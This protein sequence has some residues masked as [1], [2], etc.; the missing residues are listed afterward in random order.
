MRPLLLLLASTSIAAAEPT[1]EKVA[2]F[3][4]QVTGVTVSKTGRVFVNFPRWTEDAPVSVAEVKDGKVVPYPDAGWNGWRNAAKLS[5]KDHWICVQS[6]VADGD[7]LWVLDPASPA[8][9]G[10]VKDGAKLVAIDLATN[11]VVKTIS[12]GDDVAPPSSYLNDVRFSPD[13]KTAFLTDSGAKGAIVVVDLGNG[14]ARRLH[15]GDPSVMPDPKVDVTTDGKP[16]RRPDGRGLDAASDGIALSLDGKTLYWQALHGKTVYKLATSELAGKPQAV[17]TTFPA[18]GLWMG[19]DRLYVSSPTDDSIKTL[20]LGT[21]KVSTVIHD[22][23]LRWP[24]TFS[25]GPDGAI[26][27]TSSHIQD[28]A[29]FVPGAPK[30]LPTELWKFKP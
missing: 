12:F 17:A 24:D 15:E 8:M 25:E 11:K 2:S 13:G 20:D 14:T 7:R 9:A 3:D 29:W 18:D 19:K 5:A 16:L 1:L 30:A 4:H 28:S 22:K 26:Y 23:R 27:V 10:V 6:V 21:G